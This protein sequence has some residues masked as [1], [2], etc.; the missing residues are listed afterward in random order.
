VVTELHFFCYFSEKEKRKEKQQAGQKVN[1]VSEEE[2]IRC[3]RRNKKALTKLPG[4]T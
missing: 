2:E 1:I 3:L 4:L